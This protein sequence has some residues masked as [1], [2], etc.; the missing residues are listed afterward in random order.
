[1]ISERR[2]LGCFGLNRDRR[3]IATCNDCY[4]RG[5]NRYRCEVCKH[6]RRRS[7][8]ICNFRWSGKNK[9]Y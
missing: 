5:E 7:V 9:A 4:Y 6:G 2:C 1:M 8:R 3:C